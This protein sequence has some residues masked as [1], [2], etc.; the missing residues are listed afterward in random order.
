MRSCENAIENAARNEHNDIQ[1]RIQRIHRCQL[2]RDDGSAGKGE[3][4]EH[5]MVFC[6]KKKRFRI[7]NG[8]QKRQKHGKHRYKRGKNSDVSLHM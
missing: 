7:G 8:C 4:K 2:C 5:I 3:R 1:N 6:L